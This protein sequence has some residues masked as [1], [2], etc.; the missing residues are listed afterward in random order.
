MTGG[1]D[2]RGRFTGAA[3]GYARHRPGY[4]DVL[5]DQVLLEAGAK[6][7]DAAADLGCGT[8]ILTRML[9]ARGLAVV[10]ID[11][12]EDMLEEARATGGGA[13]YRTGDAENTGLADQ[14][15]GLVTVAQAFHWFDVDAALEE[16]QRVLTPQGHVAAI[17]NIRGENGF[18]AE[19]DALL[20]RFSSEYT[21]LE[22]WET[23]LEVLKRHP[24]VVG[25][26]E[27]R[28]EHAQRF[29]LESLRGRA[30][31]SSYV[32]RGVQDREGFDEALACLFD[33]HAQGG[34][35]VFPYRSLGLVFRVT[36]PEP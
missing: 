34:A 22:S 29:D 23:T 25:A 10:G 27:L 16:L 12:N 6:S 13:E 8:G 32:F 18:M 5:V 14:S 2:P 1:P 19:Y 17:W 7:G 35:I 3:Q 28:A 36:A 15:V 11:P 26:R 33:D 31:S 4:P 24:R 9:A 20:R 21:V 30:W